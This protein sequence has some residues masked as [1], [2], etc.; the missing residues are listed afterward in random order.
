[1]GL[2]SNQQLVSHFFNY[3]ETAS[4][5]KLIINKMLMNKFQASMTMAQGNALWEGS[6][7]NNSNQ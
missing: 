6:S 7:P 5:R 3:K 1:M 4:L 2:K